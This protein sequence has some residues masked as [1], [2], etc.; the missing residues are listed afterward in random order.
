VWPK[1]VSPGVGAPGLV[2]QAEESATR[3][4]SVIILPW[5]R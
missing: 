5:R 2:E 4:R 3:L 1:R